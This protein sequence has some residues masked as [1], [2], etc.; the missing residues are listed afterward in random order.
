MGATRHTEHYDLSQYNG[1]DKPSWLL[2]Y[3]GDMAKIDEALYNAAENATEAAEEIR[4]TVSPK[5]D[6]LDAK[7]NVLT[8]ETTV[9]KGSMTEAQNNITAL[10]NRANTA[11]NNIAGL[12]TDKQNKATSAPI[13]I[14]GVP[15]NTVEDALRAL[16]QYGG[17]DLNDYQKK[18]LSV[19]VVI[20]GTTYTTVESAMAALAAGGGGGGGTGVVYL[21]GAD[22]TSTTTAEVFNMNT[23]ASG[24]QYFNHTVQND[25]YYA[26]NAEFMAVAGSV[27][28]SASYTASIYDAAD[29]RYLLEFGN[30]D[31]GKDLPSDTRQKSYLPAQ[32]AWVYAKKNQTIRIMAF[33]SAASGST[34]DFGRITV[35]Y[36]PGVA[37]NVGGGG[38][39]LSAY[40]TKA[41]VTPIEVEGVQYTTV[42]SAMAAINALAASGGGGGG[43][44]NYN[45]LLN[46]PKINGVELTG[47]KS[48]ADL[49][50]EGGGTTNYT[51]LTNKPQINGVELSGNKTAADLGISGSA[52]YIRN[53]PTTTASSAQWTEWQQGSSG[54]GWITDNNSFVT[55]IVRVAKGAT[56]TVGSIKIGGTTLA[57]NLRFTH[58]PE[59]STS[60]VDTSDYHDFM[61]PFGCVAKGVDCRMDNVQRS[62]GSVTTP[63]FKLR[64]YEADMT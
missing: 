40:Q 59:G 23:A 26:V 22:S 64:I 12:A 38:G 4:E 21:P 11:D 15:Y 32:S 16:A 7:T 33:M 9:L 44:T 31:M 60:T 35:N 61:I 10:T 5:L 42:E 48:S 43:T 56:V 50:I 14:N 39:D 17:G 1:T 62:D 27:L 2:D 53:N 58:R 8:T 54:C 29:S 24:F 19:P 20:D 51:E 37:V 57:E 46:K 41:L 55:G 36:N 30:G 52:E 45:V 3:N 18:Q 28:A 49:H 63:C 34:L 13:L 6:E 47:D 25:G